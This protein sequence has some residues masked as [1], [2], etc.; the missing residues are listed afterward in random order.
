[1]PPRG[2][3]I[4]CARRGSWEGGINGTRL[5]MDRGQPWGVNAPD[6]SNPLPADPGV[7][8]I[9]MAWRVLTPSG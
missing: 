3:G 4:D 1:M 8:V 9:P 2:G 5:V 6:P 7:Q